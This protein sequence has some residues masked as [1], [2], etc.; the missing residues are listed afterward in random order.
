MSKKRPKPTKQQRNTF[1]I[2]VATA[3]EISEPRSFPGLYEDVA[4][5][6]AANGEYRIGRCIAGT[7]LHIF[8]PNGKPRVVIPMVPLLRGIMDEVFRLERE[9]AV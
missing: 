7:A 9:S 2:K 3:L 8:R 6:E 4:K 1:E 5:V